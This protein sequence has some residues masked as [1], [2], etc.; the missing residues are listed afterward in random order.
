MLRY[1]F[2]EIFRKGTRSMLKPG[3]TAP[4][5]ALP[6]HLG[7]T[8]RL[9]D[10]RGRRVVLFFYP[11]ADTSGCT[12]QVC[13]FRDASSAYAGKG[14]QALGISVDTVEANRAFAEKFGLEYP[15][16]CD[17]GRSVALAYRAVDSLS[18]PYARR[19]TYVI[20]ADGR[21]EQ[22][23]DTRDPGAQAAELVA[24]FR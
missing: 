14:V 19:F 24:A 6:D 12:K 23:I 8:V 4:D 20:G 18:D 13:G 2:G 3:T 1:L 9:A 17:V 16:L 21:I 5:F 15:L 22:A 10:F 7:R 11:K